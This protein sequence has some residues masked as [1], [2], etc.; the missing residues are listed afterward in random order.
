MAAAT[1]GGGDDRIKRYF[2]K[3][4]VL[5]NAN[6]E[7][8]QSAYV[9][10]ESRFEQCSIALGEGAE[11]VVGQDGVLVDCQ[12][13]G[14]GNITIHGQFFE[15]SSPGIVGP[16]KL[17]VSSHGS[18][19]GVVQQPDQSTHFAFEPGCKLRMRILHANNHG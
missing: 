9:E 15:G 14:G 17:V 18:V 8:G 4:D 19:V 16:K 13:T 3:G 11:L 1:A 7:F 10:I 5:R 2:G 12:I 6:L